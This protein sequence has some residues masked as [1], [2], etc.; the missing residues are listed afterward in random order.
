VETGFRLSSC[1]REA[2]EPRCVVLSAIQAGVF[3]AED[4]HA[5]GIHAENFD[6]KN[7]GK[8]HS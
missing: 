3:D 8:K 5:K 7:S 6:A 2:L 4:T 1:P